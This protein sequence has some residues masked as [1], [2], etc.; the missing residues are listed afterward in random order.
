MDADKIT[1][2]RLR[3]LVSYDPETGLFTNLIRRKMS[4]AGAA[5]RPKN[6]NGISMDGRLYRTSHLVWFYVHGVW[7][8]GLI[9]HID[10]NP[11]NN[12]ISN[13]READ[14]TQNGHNRRLGKNNKSGF[15]GVTKVTQA[16]R[17]QAAIRLGGKQLYLGCF[18]TP[19]MAH[20]AYRAAAKQ[21]FGEFARF[22]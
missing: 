4:L 8:H 2:A 16:N 5:L 6:R 20:E 14:K 3:S 7:P 15:K 13:L 21:H 19:E 9:D 22:S 18:A 10:A 11:E 1:H 12:K 17:W